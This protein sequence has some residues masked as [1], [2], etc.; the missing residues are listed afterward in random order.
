MHTESEGEMSL[1]PAIDIESFGRIESPRIVIPRANQEDDLLARRNR[2]AANLNVTARRPHHILGR[3]PES[4]RLLYG[5]GQAAGISDDLGS[6]IGM[7]G[8][9]MDGIGDELFGRLVSTR[10]QQETETE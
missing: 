7:P 10:N 1:H 3:A 5:G 6:L 4:K 8:K 9:L 2:L